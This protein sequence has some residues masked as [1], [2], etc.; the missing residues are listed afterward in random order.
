MTPKTK[1]WASK[2][3]VSSCFL[4]LYLCFASLCMQSDI[5][6]PPWAKGMNLTS[7]G[8]AETEAHQDGFTIDRTSS[9]HLSWTLFWSPALYFQLAL[10]SAGKGVECGCGMEKSMAATW[11]KVSRGA[12]LNVFSQKKETEGFSFTKQDDIVD[13]E[14]HGDGNMSKYTM[15]KNSIYFRHQQL[16]ESVIN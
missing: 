7:K 1:W 5:W 8:K 10:L 11:H 9:K 6:T 4:Y 14:H 15:G 16:M 2:R 12:F 13:G 3:G